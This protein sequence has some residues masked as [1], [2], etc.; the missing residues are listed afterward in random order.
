MTA[1][2]KTI[3]GTSDIAAVMRDIG[4][5]AQRRRRARLR[6][7]P[8]AQRNAALAAMAQAIRDSEA[9]ILAANAEDVAEAKAAGATAAFLD[10]L[11]LDAKARRRDGGRHRGRCATSPI[12]SAP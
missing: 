2:L 9:G 1:P 4:A 11:T 12:R 6:S 10:R 7:V 5:R 8:A 3:E